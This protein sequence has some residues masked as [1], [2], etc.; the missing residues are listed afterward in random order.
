MCPYQNGH[1]PEVANQKNVSENGIELGAM[2]ALL[3]K[4]IEELT[5]YI[6]EQERRIKAIEASANVN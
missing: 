3:L 1:L 5:L 6:I 2:I 4:K